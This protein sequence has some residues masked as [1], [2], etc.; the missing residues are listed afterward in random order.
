MYPVDVGRKN[1]SFEEKCWTTLETITLVNVKMMI[2]IKPVE[3]L[4][5][6]TLTDWL[7]VGKFG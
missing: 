6:S 1:V 5:C 4:T 7:I 2:V 3:N